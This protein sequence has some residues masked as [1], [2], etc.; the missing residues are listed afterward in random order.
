MCES[1][2]QGHGRGCCKWVS[3]QATCRV[4]H[5][6]SVVLEVETGFIFPPEGAGLRVPAWRLT[7]QIGSLPERHNHILWVLSEVV[8]QHYETKQRDWLWERLIPLIGLLL[9]QI[10]QHEPERCNETQLSLVWWSLIPFCPR[11]KLRGC[12][13][14]F[15]L[16]QYKARYS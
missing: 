11:T 8:A 4:A 15:G 7:L 1:E 10:L 5:R 14:H 12:G 2:S 9:F 6:D 16:T 13:L 3:D